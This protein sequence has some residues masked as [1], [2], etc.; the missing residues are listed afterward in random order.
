MAERNKL[1]GN[2]SLQGSIG[3]FCK[4]S[5]GKTRYADSCRQIFEVNVH[6]ELGPMESSANR[7]EG[8]R[9][10]TPESDF[11]FEK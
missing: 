5:P 10:V 4:R 2:V 7:G 9:S 11:N 8:N 6:T 1:V 3:P